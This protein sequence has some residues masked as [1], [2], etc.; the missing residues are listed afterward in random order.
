MAIKQGLH[1]A[2]ST[3]QSPSTRVCTSTQ[4]RRPLHT[5]IHPHYRYAGYDDDYIQQQLMMARAA[6]GFAPGGYGDIGYDD[7]EEFH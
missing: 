2:T 5:R 6:G 3:D 7:D 1:C 4:E